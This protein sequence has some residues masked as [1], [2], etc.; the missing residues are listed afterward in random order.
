MRENE[1]YYRRRVEMIMRDRKKIL[2]EAFEA[3]ER[4]KRESASWMKR[5]IC[6]ILIFLFFYCAIIFV[7]LFTVNLP[8]S[9]KQ[10]SDPPKTDESPSGK[11]RIPQKIPF[12]PK[13]P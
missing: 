12:L 13:R 6:L 8:D 5:L 1:R 9:P 7:L 3:C 4:E 11:E 10:K 2:D